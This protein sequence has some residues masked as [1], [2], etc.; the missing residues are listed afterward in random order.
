MLT[1]CM[2]R[3]LGVEIR[4]GKIGEMCFYLIFS[5]FGFKVA[6]KRLIFWKVVKISDF[7]ILSG[8]TEKYKPALR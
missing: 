8:W 3:F 1:E 4:I 6:D 2:W 5:F 7:Q